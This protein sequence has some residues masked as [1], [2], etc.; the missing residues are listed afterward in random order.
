MGICLI[1]Q[2]LPEDVIAHCRGSHQP[3]FR[4][5]PTLQEILKFLFSICIK[6]VGIVG[7]SMCFLPHKWTE[8]DVRKTFSMKPEGRRTSKEVVMCFLPAQ[9]IHP[10]PVLRAWLSQSS[11]PLSMEKAVS[12]QPEDT[13]P[14]STSATARSVPGSLHAVLEWGASPT[15]IALPSSMAPGKKATLF[16]SHQLLQ[17]GRWL[18]C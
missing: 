13:M 8:R 11:L 14:A 18:C 9:S 3:T 12:G 6:S 17:H 15:S 4:K 5:N 2:G 10:S 1:E 7:F 16:H